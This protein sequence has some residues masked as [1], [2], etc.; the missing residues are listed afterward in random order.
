[1][2]TKEAN[3]LCS[4]R[5]NDLSFH[6]FTWSRHSRR[7]EP[8]SRSTKGFC[9]GD[10]GAVSTFLHSHSS[11]HGDEVCSVDGISSAALRCDDEDEQDPE[12]RRRHGEKI[13]GR[14]LRKLQVGG[15]ARGSPHARQHAFEEWR[16]S[17]RK[18][19]QKESSS[20]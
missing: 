19:Q 15:E 5:R 11:G 6:T 7:I 3:P 1:M 16:Q 2:R 8:T 17:K 10:R 18:R 12:G 4:V 20:W 9:Q 13:D 14:G